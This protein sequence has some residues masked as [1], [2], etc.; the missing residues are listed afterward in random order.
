ME[1]DCSIRPK[2]RALAS[3]RLQQLLGSKPDAE[4]VLGVLGWG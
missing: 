2:Y 1:E 3:A 4:A